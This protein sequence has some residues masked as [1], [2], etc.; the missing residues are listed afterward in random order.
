[1]AERDPRLPSG[2]DDY[3]GIPSLLL[4]NPSPADGAP[5][6][7][8]AMFEPLAPNRADGDRASSLTRHHDDTGAPSIVMPVPDDVPAAPCRHPTHGTPERT[9]TYAA[10]NGRVLFFVF[11][12]RNGSKALPLTL[13]RWPDGRCDWRWKWPPPPRPIYG[14]DRLAARPNAP[15]LIVEGEKTADSAQ[16]LFTDLAVITS[17]LGAKAAS[18]ADWSVLTERRVVIWPD[19]DPEGFGYADAISRLARESGAAHAAIASIPAE[20]PAKWDLADPWPDG[21]SAA[22]AREAIEHALAGGHVANDMSAHVIRV[23]SDEWVTEPRQDSDSNWPVTLAAELDRLARLA[24]LDYDQ[25]RQE[26]AGKL[27][28]RLRT[29]DE[30]VERRRRELGY[31]APDRAGNGRELRLRTPEPHPE[32]VVGSVLLAELTATLRRYLVL[33]EGCPEAMALWAVFAHALDAFQVSPRLAF[34]SPEKRCGKTTALTLLSHL[35]PKALMSSNASGPSLF[36]VIEAQC[37]T[38]L[39][40]EAD[41]FLDDAE[42]VRN[43]LNSGQAR[44]AAF[45]L[46]TVGEDHE[47]HQF[48]TWCAIAIAKIGELPSTL[49]DRSIVVPMR[50]KRPDE[51]VDRSRIDRTSHL[52]ALASKIARWAED[53]RNALRG[54][55]PDIPAG[56]N[57]RAADNWR[58]LVAIADLVGGEWPTR[59]RNVASL[60]SGDEQSEA[61]GVRVRLLADIR[62]IFAEMGADRLTSS[63]IVSRL[64]AREDRPWPELRKGK[65]ITPTALAHIIRPFGLRPR[66]FRSGE[67]TLRGY[68]LSDFA[69]TFARY[70]PA[71][72]PQQ[73]GKNNVLCGSGAATGDNDV[74]AM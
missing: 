62:D 24:P 30:E 20:F 72:T 40:D 9:F 58:P 54:A 7:P 29:L 12:F 37:P 55:D 42:G 53:N 27:K 49:A 21:W 14:L 70:L 67:A 46:R 57:D 2:P 41:T 74:A 16:A 69:D 45:T 43:V 28:V 26:T 5:Q 51:K 32:P 36:R 65:P 22:K 50:R 34:T 60:L 66:V 52:T 73:T 13:W 10:N 8:D 64:A 17:P 23:Q 15:V 48:S 68:F 1:M 3:F 33:S 59:A 38:I 61:D 11:R 71:A 4:R 31:S 18:R 44:G 39:I 19:N 25:S 35:V 63:D 47:V 56:L 6:A